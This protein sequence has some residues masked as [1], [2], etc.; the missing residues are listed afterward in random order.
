MSGQHYV[1]SL[2][3]E[4]L[5][6]LC[7]F[8]LLSSIGTVQA[9]MSM[10][11]PHVMVGKVEMRQPRVTKK[12]VGTF[13]SIEKDPSVARVSGYITKIAFHEGAMVRQGDLLFEIENTRYQ[14]A[15]KSAEASIAQAVAKIDQCNANIKQVEAK[16]LYA[17]G[18]YDRDL[19]L[20]KAGT[21]VSED[22]VENAKSTLDALKAEL[23]S[24]KA[25]LLASEAQ[26]LSAEAALVLAEDDMKYTKIHSMITGRTG[27]LNYTLGNY[28]T[29]ASGP[30][31]TVVQM[32]PIYVKFSMS[33]K[34]FT[35]MFGTLENLRRDAQ[36][37]LQL[38]DGTF[39]TNTNAQGN[40]AEVNSVKDTARM[41]AAEFSPSAQDDMLSCL[42]PETLR[43][44]IKFID[45]SIKTATD[46][47]QIWVSFANGGQLLNPGGIARVYLTKIDVDKYPSIK[48]SAVMFS[49]E[50]PYVYVVDDKNVVQRRQVKLGTSD[51]EYRIILDGV[52]EGETVI[53]DGTHKVM[54]PGIAV[55][56]MTAQQRDDRYEQDKAAPA[57]SSVIKAKENADAKKAEMTAAREKKNAEREQA[58]AMAKQAQ[59]AAAKQM[60]GAKKP[61]QTSVKKETGK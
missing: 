18:T 53:I 52:N 43:G 6:I 44:E 38:A 7:V 49:K 54:F 4:F 14:A 21:A 25:G 50:G 57:A 40:G 15:V 26:K 34:D 36:V 29:P 22:S 3:V 5:G 59:E 10:P 28:V 39:Y 1:K 16:I 17:Q 32:D 55:V 61:G 19:A 37:T 12:Y 23:A 58:E 2:L 42:A 51:G 27:R 41:T 30:L 33:E 9:Q 11:A 35:S 46:S 48:T 56:P 24:C 45:N 31:V 20:Y 8:F 13:E 60:Q 47:I